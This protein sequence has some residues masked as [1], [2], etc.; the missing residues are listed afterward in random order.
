MV[1][2]DAILRRHHGVGPGFD[3]LRIFLA[4][5]VVFWHSWQVSYPAATVSA[6]RSGPAGILV[7]C[8]V[9]A[10]FALSGFLVTGSLVRLKNLKLFLAF[11]ALRIAPALV[12][13]I[14]LSALVLGPVVTALPLSDYFSD[15][16]FYGYFTNLV[17]LMKYQLPGVFLENPLQTVNGQ[18]WTVPAELHCYALISVLALLRIASRRSWML[19]ALLVLCFAE[20][21]YRFIPGRPVSV[22]AHNMVVLYFLSGSVIYLWRDRIPSRWPLALAG[23]AIFAVAVHAPS[24][25][26]P[27]LAPIPI[28]YATIYFGL[29]TLPKLPILMGGDYSYGIYLYSFPIQQAVTLAF[30]ALRHWYFN[31]ALAAPVAILFAMLSWH[32]LEKPILRLRKRLAPTAAIPRTVLDESAADAPAVASSVGA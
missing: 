28:S 16:Q 30:P 9:P 29:K 3:F 26:R 4:L 31:F 10:F 24:P 2:F 15:W 12:T 25:L 5:S 13:E 8:I 18:L 11:R 17:G 21:L 22:E 19:A 14:M 7:F 27:L 1:T 23:L 6:I 20:T 32:L